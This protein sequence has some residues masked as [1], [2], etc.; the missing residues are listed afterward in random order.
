MGYG[1]A[2]IGA[3][4]ACPDEVVIDIDE[5][6]SFC[7]TGMELA[8][9]VQFNIGVKEWSN[10]GKT[11]FMKR[12]NQTEMVNPDFV[13]LAES[14]GAKALRTRKHEHVYPMV[15]AGKGL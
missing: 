11:Y 13:K 9:A 4:V 3:K 6:A 7:M 8:T 10:N 5:D 14:I 15:S 2:A 12:D 1:P